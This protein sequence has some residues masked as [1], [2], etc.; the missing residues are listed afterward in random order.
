MKRIIFY[1]ALFV[2]FTAAAVGLVIYFVS[3]LIMFETLEAEEQRRVFEAVQEVRQRKRQEQSYIP[4]AKVDVEYLAKLR[5]IEG[6]LKEL[7]SPGWRYAQDFVD[8][9][10]KYNLPWWLL[11][12]ICVAESG[13]GKQVFLKNNWFGWG[14]MTFKTPKDGIW[15]VG[16]RLRGGYFDKGC[17][18][19]NCI[20]KV[21]N[22]GYDV[23]M[24]NVL[25][26]KVRLEELKQIYVTKLLIK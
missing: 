11:P 2:A 21:Y 3:A 25:A 16:K 12:S 1:L 14:K 22:G 18:D 6:Y 5:A 10:E 15:H 8:V 13:C 17:D 7:K 23:W 19:L 4:P 20:H 26:S 9:S 24:R